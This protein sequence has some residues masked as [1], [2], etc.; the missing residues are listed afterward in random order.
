MSSNI[1]L[2]T[3]TA[4]TA[5][6]GRSWKVFRKGY[7]FSLCAAPFTIPYALIYRKM[8]GKQKVRTDNEVEAKMSRTLIFEL[9]YDVQSHKIFILEPVIEVVRV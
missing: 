7:G 5:E 8:I 9:K 1:L 4:E 2:R 6:C 3:D